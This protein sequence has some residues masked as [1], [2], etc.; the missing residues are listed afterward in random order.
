MGNPCKKENQMESNLRPRY[1]RV[2]AV[3]AALLWVLVAADAVY[4][5][6]PVTQPASDNHD[7]KWYLDEAIKSNEKAKASEETQK[8]LLEKTLKALNTKQSETLRGLNGVPVVVAPLNDE[9][10]KAGLTSAIIKQDA[11]LRLR[12]LGINVLSVEESV[13]APG[14][15]CL[16]IAVEVFPNPKPFEALYVYHIRV[17]VTQLVSLERHPKVTFSA[18]TWESVSPYG[19]VGKDNLRHLRDVVADGVDQFAN[20]YL[21]ENPKK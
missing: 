3:S 1:F 15:P 8:A 5:Q 12:R 21:A 17:N 20:E 9:I 7:A 14:V 16:I 6:V 18:V 2:A 4:A 10:E 11:E 13:N 19:T